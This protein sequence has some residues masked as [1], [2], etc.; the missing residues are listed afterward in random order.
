MRIDQWLTS[1]VVLFAV[2]C[3]GSDDAPTPP[4]EDSSVAEA[5]SDTLAPD[6]AAPDTE[7]PDTVVLDT[8]MSDTAVVETSDAADSAVVD[9]ADTSVLPDTSVTDTF[10]ADTFVADTFVADTA[11]TAMP[12]A[13]TDSATLSCGSAPYQLFDPLAAMKVLP[14]TA[15]VTVTV[16]TCPTTAVIIPNGVNRTMSVQRSTPFFTIATQPGSLPHLSIEQN[17]TISAFAKLAHLVTMY[18]TTAAPPLLPT[19][20][21]TK[22]ALL[23]M[24][25]NASTGAGACNAKDGVTYAVPGHTEAVVTYTGGGTAT[26]GGGDATAWIRLDTTGTR[27][28]PEYVTVT[29]TKSGCKVGLTSTDRLFLTGRAP[30]AIGHLTMAMGG[31]V[32]NP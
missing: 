31:E 26:A 16:N 22:H 30:I 3:T 2:A 23:R 4:V 19:W 20:D 13:A 32:Q 18:P 5:A 12:D 24:V 14:N 6:T 27:T 17:V 8:A 21:P 9:A 28:T 29:Q 25:V 15:D 7:L 10:V 11:D 1:S